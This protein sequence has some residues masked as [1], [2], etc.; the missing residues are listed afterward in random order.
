MTRRYYIWTIGCQMNTA[1]SRAVAE[2][3]E[4]RGFLPASSPEQADVIV[5]NTCVV[6][7][8]AEQ[9]ARGRLSSL[10]PVKQKRP[11]AVLAVMGCLVGED[12]ESLRR[13]YPFVDLFLRPSHPEPLF[14][15]LDAGGCGERLSAPVSPV[16]VSAYLPISYGCDHHCTYCIVRLRRGPQRSR[17]A[18]DIYRDAL[19]LVERGAREIILLG[20]NV[21]AYGR[22]LP[23]GPDLA[24]LLEKLHDI[25]GLWRLRFLT[26]HPAD[27][28][29]R[30]IEAVAELP[31]VCEHF[32]LPVQSGSDV[33]L[34]RMGRHYTAAQYLEL[35]ERIRARLPDAGL[36]TDVIVGFCGETEEDFQA[37]R[38]LLETVRFD[39]VH[40]AAYSVRPGTPAERL[41]DD[42]PPEVKEARRQELEKLQERIAGEIN[43]ALLGKSV[44]VLVEERQKGRWRGRTRQNK[45][46]FFDST[47]ELAGAL[48][49]VR[50]TWAGPWSLIG[51]LERIKART[52]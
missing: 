7:E 5:L 22:D 36:A 23:G 46:V 2:G 52:P 30:L 44:E 25:P 41:P 27:M 35:V 51:E 8:S 4:R 3:L 48:V 47:E 14:A 28:Q 26:S 45:L 40:I 15:L 31:K 33:V 6:R 32:E 12:E 42:V 39:V 19:E 1:D 37:T 10:R 50:I 16:P 29:E 21:D 24:G 43:A 38:R 13:E 18:E 17:P 34:R 49:D 20:Q 9:R 11:G